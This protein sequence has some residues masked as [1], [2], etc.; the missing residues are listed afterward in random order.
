MTRGKV[1][2]V[3]L[4]SVFAAHANIRAPIIVDRAPTRLTAADASLRVLAES[5]E[6]HCPAAFKGNRDMKAFA[7]RTC[8]A[9]IRYRVESAG[10]KA[11]FSFFFSGQG[12]VKWRAAE[13]TS[14]VKPRAVKIEDKRSCW[15]CPE[16]MRHVLV[17]QEVLELPAGKQDITIE[18]KQALSYFESGHSYFSD[19]K[20]QQEFTY[21]LWPIAEWQWANDFSAELKFSVAMRPGF[22]GIGYKGDIMRCAIDENGTQTELPLTAPRQEGIRRMVTARIVLAKKP[23]RLRCSYIAD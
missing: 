6:F 16:D 3:F 22:L 5:L 20:W 19:G 15:S 7:E 10:I 18:Y 2:S 21:E 1:V 23:Q 17:A 8:D 11:K 4:L 13:K 14:L 9:T 12:E